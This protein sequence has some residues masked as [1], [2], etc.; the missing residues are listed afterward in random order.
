MLDPAHNLLTVQTLRVVVIEYSNFAQPPPVV[1]PSVTNIASAKILPRVRKL[2]YLQHWG[3][4]DKCRKKEKI[5]KYS[6]F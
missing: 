1:Y 6:F 4:I 3:N 2:K 5:Q